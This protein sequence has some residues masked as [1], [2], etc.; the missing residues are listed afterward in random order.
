MQPAETTI[1]AK[2]SPQVSSLEDHQEPQ[3]AINLSSGS[4]SASSQQ[5]SNKLHKSAFSKVESHY[6]P[7][8]D[9]DKRHA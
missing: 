1:P 6:P 7:A 4:K 5:Q 8:S 2:H 9:P 3:D